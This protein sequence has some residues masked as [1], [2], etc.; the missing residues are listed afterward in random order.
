MAE[1]KFVMKRCWF[2]LSTFL[3]SCLI[4]GVAM[5]I[6]YKK[7]INVVEV[8]TV[9]KNIFVNNI[10]I[11]GMNKNDALEKIEKVLQDPI[12]K[13]IIK[14]TDGNGGEYQ[15]SFKDFNASYN[16]KDAMQK[17]YDYGREG[18]LLK[19]YEQ[20]S[21]LK[22]SPLKI[23]AAYNFNNDFV[24]SKLSELESKVYIKPINA[25]VYRADNKF[26]VTSGKDGRKLN[27]DTTLPFLIKLLNEKK[28]GTVELIFDVIQP[29][30]NESDFDNVKN[31]L[32]SYTT[33]F[34]GTNSQ[35]NI[36]IINA[37][38]KI[39]NS[40][41]YPSEIFSVN[42]ALKP[43]TFKNGYRNA[44]VIVE[45]KIVDDLG[46]GICQ[47]STALYNA[48]LY[49]ELKVTERQNHSLK[50]G[51]VDYGYDATLAGNYID[52]KFKNTTR[53]PVLI[54][55]IVNSNRLIINIYGAEMRPASHKIK[56]ENV[57]VKII[58][59]P[60]ETIVY[61]DELPNGEKKIVSS[62][63]KGYQY[64]LYKIVY[65]NGVQKDKILV[66]TSY[67]KATRGT[68]KIGTKE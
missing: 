55:S 15:F 56:F 21:K 31:I 41:V 51:Y 12:N 29:M 36:N 5:H 13:K 17:A 44:P 1:K 23:T 37:A 50:V 38:Q 59:A 22:D 10:D 64:K 25:S 30:Y 40:V 7:I 48:V 32:G 58:P 54:E 45:G 6:S 47:V 67:Y 34:T 16:I 46:G 49:S 4:I 63:R 53:T 43:F 14:F 24:K 8:D 39:N 20:I 60:P 42:S 2:F 66:N 18:S 9:Y 35:R 28:E 3:L 52:L 26:I 65:E 61:T 19:R 11:G 68:I 57:L 27:L 62:S 33:V